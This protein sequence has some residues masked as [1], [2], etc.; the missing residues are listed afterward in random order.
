MLKLFSNNN[1]RYS[2]KFN[3]RVAKGEIVDL[4][5]L[6]QKSNVD[7]VPRRS[8]IRELTNTTR[9]TRNNIRRAVND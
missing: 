3:G 2:K 5:T 6:S 8:D 4:P 7:A 1:G 9:E